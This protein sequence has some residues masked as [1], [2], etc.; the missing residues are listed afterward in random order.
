LS[1]NGVY[2]GQVG[3]VAEGVDAMVI[4]SE[5]EE[6]EISDEV[7]ELT[8]YDWFSSYNQPGELELNFVYDTAAMRVVTID[9]FANPVVAGTYVLGD[10]LSE[11][12]CKYQGKIMQECTVVVTENTDGNLTFDANFVVDYSRYH[13]TWTGNPATLVD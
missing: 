13:F 2:V 3:S 4:P 9:F 12:Y 5:Y 10:N 8:I 11:T 7:T 6:P 1:F